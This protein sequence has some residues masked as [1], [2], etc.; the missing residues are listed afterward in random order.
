[1]VRCLL[2]L[3]HLNKRLIWYLTLPSYRFWTLSL[4]V[5]CY[6]HGGNE[7]NLRARLEDM[8]EIE[9]KRSGKDLLRIDAPMNFADGSRIMNAAIQVMKTLGWAWRWAEWWVDYNSSWEPLLE[10]GQR[11]SRMTKEQ[12]KIVDS[13]RESRCED[14][15]RCR[16]AAFGAALRNREYDT[17]EG[18]NR[19]A[20]DKALRA[21]LHTQSLVG[22]LTK[23]EIDFFVEWLSRAYRSNSRL[24]GFGDFK[25]SV[26]D[27]TQVCVHIKDQSPKNAL[28]NRPVP[29]T[30]ELQED[31][32][33]EASTD[34]VDDFM[35]RAL[36]VLPA[37]PRRTRDRSDRKRDGRKDRK[38]D[39]HRKKS[40]KRKAASPPPPPEEPEGDTD[41][42]RS[43]AVAA[44]VPSAVKRRGQPPNDRSRVRPNAASETVAEAATSKSIPGKRP[45]G[46][47]RR[48]PSPLPTAET[49]ALDAAEAP[50]RPSAGRKRRSLSSANAEDS[51]SECDASAESAPPPAKRRPGRPS[52]SQS[53]AVAEP[54]DSGSEFDPTAESAPPPAKR[55]PVRPSR[56]Q[57]SA[58][59]EPE[60]SGSE[61][62]PTETALPPPPAKK[63]LGRPPKNPAT[64]KRKP[65]RPRKDRS[66]LSS[67]VGSTAS[68]HSGKRDR[69]TDQSDDMEAPGRSRSRRSRSSSDSIKLQEEAGVP[70]GGGE[71]AVDSSHRNPL[72]EPAAGA[73]PTAG[74]EKVEDVNDGSPTNHAALSG[75][76]QGNA[77]IETSRR[78][79]PRRKAH[80]LS[81]EPPAAEPLSKFDLVKGRRRQA[82]RTINVGKGPAV[83]SYDSPGMP[84]SRAAELQE[85]RLPISEL[86]SKRKDHLS[87]PQK[88]V[89]SRVAVGVGSDDTV[90]NPSDQ[91][92][93][94]KIGLADTSTAV[95][96]EASKP[97]ESP[98]EKAAK[99]VESSTKQDEDTPQ[100]RG[101]RRGKKQA[102]S[103][104]TLTLHGLRRPHKQK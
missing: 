98:P 45:P 96:E 51:G 80:G 18:F 88:A 102:T 82:R 86:I 34:E 74:Q 43:A 71:S 78:L 50:Q 19:E 60:D 55:R 63:K 83:K 35:L 90:H 7:F 85:D 104:I 12:L 62:E 56:N 81:A 92:E 13:T 47:P 36:V 11:E 49:A 66:T 38:R 89:V 64:V 21:V 76:A 15:R 100:K 28:G 30:R 77:T 16:L 73:A 20:L 17:P 33:F 44:V 87:P 101:R 3:T 2:V 93:T 95:G 32:V 59:A 65:G 39:R 99:S 53:S 5:R 57:S 70:G 22:P 61:F 97:A 26:S 6:R 94:E 1:M 79:S 52:R 67:D 23:K 25:I 31:G 103:Q 69:S 10:P 48:K 54:E 14:A 8:I 24:L 72:S 42:D 29:G 58:I 37:K 46:R 68:A 91:T 4:A 9:K 75:Q 84:V 27:K 40:G 41:G